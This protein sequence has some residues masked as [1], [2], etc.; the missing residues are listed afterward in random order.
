MTNKAELVQDVDIQ[1]KD[2]PSEEEIFK[3]HNNKQIKQDHLLSTII[4]ILIRAT[5]CRL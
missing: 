2:Y 1:D 5:M 4:M 3:E